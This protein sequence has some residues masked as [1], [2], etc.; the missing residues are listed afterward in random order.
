[1]FW[2]FS[3]NL[4]PDEEV[5]EDSTQR[6]QPAI[7]ASYSI[8]LTNKRVIFRFDGLGSSLTLSFFYHE[9]VSALPI[10]RFLITY[11]DVKTEKRNIVMNISEVEYWANRIKEMQKVSVEAGI[12]GPLSPQISPQVSP[13]RKKRELFDMLIVLQKNSLITTEELEQKIHMLDSLKL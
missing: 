12:P 8:F 5:I 3:F 9:I 2:S 13:E 4:L 1:M 7:R 10:K 6:P 11:L